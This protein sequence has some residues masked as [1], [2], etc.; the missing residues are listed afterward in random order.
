MSCQFDHF[1]DRR[2][3]CSKKW[4][5]VL[6]LFG[7]NNLIPMWIAD[8]DFRPPEEVVQAVSRR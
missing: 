7:E 4:D 5:D 1:I 6:E 2:N 8:M 3:T